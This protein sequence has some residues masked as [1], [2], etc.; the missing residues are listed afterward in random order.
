MR[1]LSLLFPL[2]LCTFLSWSQNP[3]TIFDIPN[4]NVTLSCGSSCISITATV[5]H[6]KQ[7]TDYIVTQMPYLPFAYSTPGGTEVTTIYTDD[8]WS[9]VITPGFPFC[10][11]GQT[12]NGL[13]MGSNSNITFDLTRAGT[14][15]G[16][17]ITATTPIPQSQSTSVYAPASIFGPYHDI[18]PA[19]SNNPA[20]T[21]RKIEWRVEGT[22]PTRRFIGSYNDVAYFGSS[23]N[24]FTST[25]QMVLYENTGV[26]E[27]YIKDKPVCT[28]W[29]N[30]LT[31]LGVQDE[32]RTKAVAAPGKNATQWGT[33]GMNE[34]YRFT[35]SG[36][37]TMFQRAE[38]VANGV[39]V[40]LAD[41]A[42][43]A[44]GHLNLNFNNVC[45]SLDSTAFVLRVVYSSCNNPA[46]EFAFT[47]T[48]FVK[49]ATPI[50]NVAFTNATCAGG[51]TI[52]AT[53]TGGLGTFQYSLNAGTSQ[54]SNVFN[55]LQAGTYAVTVLNSSGCTINNLVTI[56]LNDNLN[57]SVTPADTSLCIGASFTPVVTSSGTSFSWSP[58][59]GVSNPAI[60]NPVLTVNQNTTYT[61][62]AS[63]GS[64][65]RQATVNAS[66]FPGVQVNAGPA[67]TII[68][69]GSVQ[70]QG[71]SSQPGTY[72]WT[73]S[74]GLSATNILKPTASPQTTTTYQL[75]VTTAQGC[76]DSAT[77]IVNVIERCD[78]PMPAFTP[79]GDG[80]NDTWWVTNPNCLREARVQIFNRYGAK[81]FESNNYQNNWNGT[82]KG[83]PVP[84]GT[85]Y[86]VVQYR[87]VN[88]QLVNKRGNI[89]I[90][91]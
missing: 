69:G 3:A 12:Y 61:V 14:G 2:L 53:A 8:T 77:T 75:R 59:T 28:S 22:A 9:P 52:T 74:Q 7:T 58:S 18:N 39:V 60:R 6:I 68:L 78:D 11:Y 45:P 38:L 80:I 41:T 5:P 89:S 48:V 4:R 87:L 67:Q 83:K 47:D 88:N 43:G 13:V 1:K 70:L 72:L 91:R 73:P 16:Y 79:N 90:L 57:L 84:D 31:I 63:L 50:V 85:Y 37:A 76:V 49:K 19:A 23:C 71:S 86:F 24:T 46:N 29:N 32:T 82:Y 62:T 33:V 25:H 21:N 30:G 26:V 40:A 44:A 42:S 35:P 81:V 56:G 17:V 10:F 54:A 55:N 34:A 36:G 64:C 51:G 27:V 66:V 20:P 65:T 15:S